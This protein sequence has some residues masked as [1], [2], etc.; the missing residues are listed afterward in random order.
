METFDFNLILDKNF[1]TNLNSLHF[2][3][4]IKIKKK[5]NINSD[6]SD[7]TIT[8]NNFF[9]HWIKETSITK[10]GTNIEK[11]RN[12]SILRFYAQALASG[13]TSRNSK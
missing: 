10:Y 5:T 13:I 7:D 2:V 12:L 4:L 3:F 6:I 1:Y 8:V 9:A 11:S